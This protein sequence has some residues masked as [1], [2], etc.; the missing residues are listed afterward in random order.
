MINRLPRRAP[1]RRRAGHGAGQVSG[2]I[3]M[4]AAIL[5][6]AG[7]AT[8]GFVAAGKQRQ[9][10]AAAAASNDDDIYTGS[11]LYM[12]D[13][14]NICRQ[15]LFDNQDGQLSDNGY[16]DC[17]QAAYHGIDGPKQWSAARIRVIATGFRG[18]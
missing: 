8:D 3:A 7:L 1:K 11:I 10:V 2:V 6:L 5:A 14:S 16:V 18:Q 4:G 15:L 17:E 9:A 13:T 12:P